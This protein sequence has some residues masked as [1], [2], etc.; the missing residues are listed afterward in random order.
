MSSEAVVVFSFFMVSVV[1][2]VSLFFIIT[3]RKECYA[4]YVK[5]KTVSEFG[6]LVDTVSQI[7]NISR[8]TALRQ[9]VALCETEIK[10][11]HLKEMDSG[12]V[13]KNSRDVL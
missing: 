9:I 4:K 5:G 7:N 6:K 3:K 2:L 8:E 10:L 13:E 1:P 11:I 12:V